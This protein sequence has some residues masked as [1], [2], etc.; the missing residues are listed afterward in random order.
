[1]RQVLASIALR[2]LDPRKLIL[3]ACLLVSMGFVSRYVEVQSQAD[4]SLALMQGPPEP[5]AI[6]DFSFD[7]N[8]GPA[9]EVV[10]RAEADF[11]DPLIVT[12]RGSRPLRT[13]VI[14]PLYELSDE[15]AERFENTASTSLFDRAFETSATPT[16]QFNAL[17]FIFHELPSGSRDLSDLDAVLSQEVGFGKIGSVIELTGQRADPGPFTLIL[18]GALAAKGQVLGDTYLAMTPYTQPREAVLNANPMLSVDEGLNRIAFVLLLIAAAMWL[19]PFWNREQDEMSDIDDVVPSS[20]PID[21]PL[22]APIA[23]Q[24]ELHEEARKE[25]A[26]QRRSAAATTT[27]KAVKASASA[28]SAAVKNSRSRSED[29]AL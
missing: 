1:M 26:E 23:S 15:G 19:H 20:G 16:E 11:S 2:V 14:I 7:T 21:H 28:L 5:V 10:V 12:L 17:G 3:V 24:D 9:D 13:A 4:R 22:F 8:V 6:Q 29:E 27:V 18:D 25:R